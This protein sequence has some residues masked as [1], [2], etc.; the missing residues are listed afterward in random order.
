MTAKCLLHLFHKQEAHPVRLKRVYVVNTASFI[1]QVMALVRPLIKS[2]L[3]GLLKFTSDGPLEFLTKDLL[4][5]VNYDHE[6]FD[7][8]NVI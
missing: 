7:S 6:T 4:P 3:F 2:E 1:N 5:R 8:M